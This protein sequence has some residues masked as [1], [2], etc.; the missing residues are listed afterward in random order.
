MEEAQV[1]LAFGGDRVENFT[2]RVTE[3][4]FNRDTQSWDK[5]RGAEATALRD[6]ECVNPPRMRASRVIFG[7]FLPVASFHVHIVLS[8]EVFDSGP[9]GRNMIEDKSSSYVAK[10]RDAG[11]RRLPQVSVLFFVCRDFQPTSNNSTKLYTMSE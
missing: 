3:L 7:P 11:M 10:K 8:A 5:T 2:A 4:P 1:L 6:E 9:A